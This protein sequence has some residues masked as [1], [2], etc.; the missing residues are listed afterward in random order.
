MSNDLQTDLQDNVD[1]IQKDYKQEIERLQNDIATV[2]HTNHTTAAPYIEYAQTTGPPRKHFRSSAHMKHMWDRI[3]SLSEQMG[4][5]E[6]K[7]GDC[8]CAK[9]L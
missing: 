9:R 4:L 8:K 7:L 5:L 2:Q 6:E 3:R 1:Q